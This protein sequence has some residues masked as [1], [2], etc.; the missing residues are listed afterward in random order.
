[1]A[2]RGLRIA[3]RAELTFEDAGVA[4][5]PGQTWRMLDEAS[6][7]VLLLDEDIAGDEVATF[8]A[9]CRA[10]APD[11]RIVVLAADVSPLT[12]GVLV[13][14]GAS[15]VV[16]K[17]AS[18]ADVGTAIRSTGS[19][20]GAALRA[21]A[22]GWSRPA[23]DRPGSGDPA[24]DLMIATLSTREREVL[25]LM[26]GGSSNPAIAAEL[27]LSVNTVRKHV[28]HVLVKLGVHSKLEAAAFAAR[29]GLVPAA[30]G[31]ARPF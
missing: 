27:G 13:G 21:S 26:A 17:S 11:V 28:E 12:V 24:I 3:L 8:L 4:T 30:G 16:P 20:P 9:E 25:R 19:A 18:V 7:S 22:G 6:P 23:A 31:T 1:V 5:S 15:E 14:A 29:H 10:V 2:G